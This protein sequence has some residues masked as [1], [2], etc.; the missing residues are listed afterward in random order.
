MKNRATSLQFAGQ[1]Q[2]VNDMSVRGLECVRPLARQGVAFLLAFTFPLS[3][4]F[5]SGSVSSRAIEPAR[6][7]GRVPYLGQRGMG[8]FRLR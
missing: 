5:L 3:Q 1:V 8:N 4:I 2:G 6:M 7:L